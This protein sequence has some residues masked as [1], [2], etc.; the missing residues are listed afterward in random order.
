MKE[1]GKKFL[2]FY[3]MANQF[4]HD[5]EAEK[6]AKINSYAKYGELV[7]KLLA[8]DKVLLNDP[9][10]GNFECFIQNF[11]TGSSI[12]PER[13]LK[14]NDDYTQSLRI[15]KIKNSAKHG[16]SLIRIYNTI[17]GDRLS[18]VRLIMLDPVFGEFDCL[19]H[20]FTK[21]KA[22]HPKR[23]VIHNKLS[24]DEKLTRINTSAKNGEELL[25]FLPGDKIRMNDP[26][27]GEY[28]CGFNTFT[29]KGAEHPK[30]RH[31]FH[32]TKEMAEKKLKDLGFDKIIIKSWS[33]KSTEKSVFIDADGVEITTTLYLLINKLTTR[34]SQKVRVNS[35]KYKA[36]WADPIFKQMMRD[37]ISA[38]ASRPETI[39]K[40]K[41]TMLERTGF[42]SP[43]KNPETLKKAQAKTLERHGATSFAKSKE[44]QDKYV[45]ILRERHK[46]ESG[47]AIKE[48]TR[49][50]R[51]EN[52]Q[53]FEF[54]GKTVREWAKELGKA[55]S[56]LIAQVKEYGFEMAIRV[57]REKTGIEIRME[58]LLRK[59][60]IQ[61]KSQ[62]W[63]KDG[64]WIYDF[65]V[66]DRFVIECN[67]VYWHS[68][69]VVKDDERHLKKRLSV[70]AE[71]KELLMFLEP[72]IN[73]K[74]EIIEAIILDR[75]G[76]TKNPGPLVIKQLDPLESEAVFGAN[77]LLGSAGIE[78]QVIFDEAGKAVAGVQFRAGVIERMF[79]AKHL[80]PVLAGKELTY[81]LDLRFED[82]KALLDM[83]FK[84]ESAFVDFVWTKNKIV[85][86]K[87]K[88]PGDSGYSQ[89]MS[90]LW[91]C[92]QVTLTTLV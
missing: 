68:D 8:I 67:G 63:S 52:G 86:P 89:G 51:V 12:H 90:K 82:P 7:V 85:E 80:G 48:K 21:G 19:F 26:V 44:W 39:A 87:A 78:S 27:Y 47:I 5:T 64:K 84:I 1:R 20:K 49:K 4:R 79:G 57:T 83:G 13:R 71:G 91:D 58:E 34:P 2:R 60:N 22:I 36:R 25:E 56:T 15:E 62:R 16:E 70:E 43:L 30:R 6:I 50:S 32:T 72:E 10:Y 29:R 28:V 55:Y 24:L 81:N 74:I 35:G 31:R 40:R 38:A 18:S 76:R 61:Y 14:I 3:F 41:K 33:G 59:N 53:T 11:R 65:V 54:E 88:Y 23:Y 92:G 42:D 46:G 37:K 69:A 45:P 66:E 75:L 17:P 73:H 9:E 77:H